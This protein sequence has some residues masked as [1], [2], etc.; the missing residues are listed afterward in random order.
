MSKPNFCEMVQAIYATK[1]TQCQ[2]ANEIGTGQPTVHK[3]IH[4]AY[5]DD[6][7]WSIGDAI[8]RLH[9]KRCK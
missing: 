7:K 9:R 1:M 8:I 3:F 6:P 4:N 5:K 2:I